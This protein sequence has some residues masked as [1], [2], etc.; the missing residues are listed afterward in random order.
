[1]SQPIKAL[2]SL[3]Q[4][5]ILSNV[6]LAIIHLIAAQLG[7][8]LAH[9]ETHVTMVWP[10]AGIALTAI[11]LFGYRVWPGLFIADVA[12]AALEGH[13]PLMLALGPLGNTLAAVVG[14]GALRAWVDFDVRL[15]RVKDVLWLTLV[16]GLF[17]TTLGAML[18]VTA[19]T[20]SGRIAAMNAPGAWLSWWLRDTVG[21]TVIT[22][23]FLVIGIE[24]K[25]RGALPTISLADLTDVG[26]PFALLLAVNA[27][28]FGGAGRLFPRS[29]RLPLTFVV[30]PPL[31]WIAMGFGVAGSSVAVLFTGIM[32]TVGTVLG[33][34]P[35]SSLAIQ[36]SLG[37]LWSFVGITA[38]TTLTLGAAVTERREA[39]E[40][41]AFQSMLLDQIQDKITATDLGG[42]ITYVNEAECRA[43]GT[44]ADELIGQSVEAYG[45]DP[46]RGATQREII[47][48]VRSEG[49]WQGDVVNFTADGRAIVLD[50]RVQLIY[51]Q[52]GEPVGM[53]GISTDIT[54]RKAM[55]RQ[56]RQQE[57]LAAV[58]QLAAGIAHDFRNLLTTIILYAGLPLRN[59]D[60]PPDLTQSLETIMAEADKATDLVQQILDFSSS[61][62]I[63]R[64]PLELRSFVNDFLAVLRR[65]IP[66]S[67]DITLIAAPGSYTVKADAGRLQQVLMNLA[68]NARDA[69]PQGGELQFRLSTVE[70]APEALLP[71]ADMHP[72]D[73]IRLDVSDTGTGMTEEVQE[74]LFE[75][76]FTTKE[77]G[78]G[79]GL[80]LAQV[81]GIVR[82]HEGAIDV[83]TEPGKGTIFRIYL[84]THSGR[85]DAPAEEKD[86]AAT[87]G[88][89]GHGETILLVED[90]E[91]LRR[92]TQRML[93][94][95]GYRVLAAANGREALALCQSPRRSAGSSPIDL[96]V[97]DLV[98]PEMGG[99]E[100]MERLRETRHGLKAVAIT[101]YTLDEVDRQ[102]LRKAGFV[103]VLRK[104]F[105]ADALAQPIGRAL[106]TE[107]C[108]LAEP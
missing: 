9:P 33:Y 79:T 92:A 8:L 27:I 95:L 19:L 32:A 78:E 24:I 46:E 16:G 63:K 97:T 67:I 11:L 2:R 12:V 84:P 59:H 17:A 44:P 30:V 42:R 85:E 107:R 51:D 35:F 25:D 77:V 1:M 69:M 21:V 89:R 62:M 23:I 64:R 70:V 34:G 74:H 47:K 61:A 22:P 7:L 81:Y 6:V 101:G 54:R 28:V 29:S 98:M 83:E 4:H 68:L 18:G 45:E 3:P 38:F 20:V 31:V 88:P 91:N 43:F 52:N 26:P 94:T 39:Q 72:G 65:T 108:P 57:R 105:E 102:I 10:P 36:E 106:D 100:L 90:E 76:F 40:Q 5:T 60:L 99:R 80:G 50:S 49:Q 48:S 82:Q 56:L 96:V 73:W 55:E 75:P 104:P 71:V 86:L 13:P 93:E 53:L 87:A 58:G 37:V 103:D 14:A 41:L 66:E 15:R